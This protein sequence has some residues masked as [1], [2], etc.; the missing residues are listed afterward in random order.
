[1]RLLAFKSMFIS[2]HAAKGCVFPSPETWASC[3]SAA[4][5]ILDF[6]RFQYVLSAPKALGLPYC[7]LSASD[8]NMKCYDFVKQ[9]YGPRCPTHWFS[10]MNSQTRQEA[11]VR[12]PYAAQGCASASTNPSFCLVG[13]P[14]HPYSTQRV[15]R[16]AIESVTNHKDT[17]LQ[18][19]F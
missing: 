17:Q 6:V 11:C 8:M 12:H 5:S 19:R 2:V 1:M 3:S 13:S 9:N 7:I 14:C 4:R 16:F 10:T 18:Q 15:G